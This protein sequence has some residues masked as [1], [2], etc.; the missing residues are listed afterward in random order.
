VN[1]APLEDKG[2]GLAP[3]G[4]GWFTVNVRDAQW[5]TTEG[6][7]LETSGSECVFETQAAPFPQYGFRLH[8]LQPGESN[9]LYHGENQQED[10]LVLS[11]EC[12]MLVEGEERPLQAWDFVHC[13]PW[14]EHIFV[15]AGSGPCVILMAGARTEP[16]E[17]VYPLSDFAARHN[18]GAHTKTSDPDEAYGGRAEPSR[19]GRPSFWSQLPW[20]QEGL[21]Q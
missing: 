1:E 21:A 15:G 11:G 20:A 16:W 12:L 7:E 10:F 9:G 4:E 3:A 8:V 17:V 19:R 6:G 5:L 14:T 2:S 13:P 18:A